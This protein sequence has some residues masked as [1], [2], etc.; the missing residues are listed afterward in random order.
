MGDDIFYL[1]FVDVTLNINSKWLM[2]SALEYC[3]A[4]TG[5]IMYKKW[6]F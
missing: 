6:L 3:R 1:T 2:R 5:R 4:A